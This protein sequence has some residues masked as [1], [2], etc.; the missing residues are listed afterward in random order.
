MV[1][2]RALARPRKRSERFE[3]LVRGEHTESFQSGLQPQ[4]EQNQGTWDFQQKTRNHRIG[5]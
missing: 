1:K 5:C 3:P 4:V 2:G